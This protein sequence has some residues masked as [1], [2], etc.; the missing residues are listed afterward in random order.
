LR[1][2]TRKEAL[3]LV[4]GFADRKHGLHTTRRSTRNDLS[5]VVRKGGIVQMGVDI[6]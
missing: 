3:R 1:K 5:Q 4:D 2:R 6:T